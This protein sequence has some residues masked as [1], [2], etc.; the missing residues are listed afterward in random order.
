MT[1]W[2]NEPPTTP[3]SAPPVGPP[4]AE[5]VASSPPPPVAAAPTASAAASSSAASSSVPARSGRGRTIAGVILA[6]IAGFSALTGLASFWATDE[7][8]SSSTWQATSR[9]IVTDPTVQQD[10]ADAISKQIVDTVG[11]QSIVSGLLPGVLSGF[12]GTITDKATD[13]LSQATLLAVR[14]QFF[15]DLWQKAVSAT[16]DQFVHAIDG[17]GGGMTAITSKGIELDLGGVVTE[18]QKQLD[19]KGIHV[20]DSV[21]TSNLHVTYLLVDAPGL[22]SLRTWVRVLRV[23]DI[24]LPAIAVIGAIAALIIARRRWFA[25]AALGAGGLLGAGALAIAESM[26]RDQA[27]QRLSGGVIGASTAAVV[28]DHVTAGLD[29]AVLVAAAVS[30]GVLVVGI[31]GVILTTP[32]R[33][34][35]S[36]SSDPTP[37]AA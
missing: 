23:L 8:L 1:D 37:A 5:S 11:V 7:I 19:A 13:L 2:S 15:E 27:I 33:R 4:M 21:D 20:L 34:T 36:T 24:V 26:W 18:V 17:S 16:H 14:T 6:L 29:G 32:R 22:E 30:V 10:V 35:G 31:L 3:P 28:V 9:A 25:V 12:S